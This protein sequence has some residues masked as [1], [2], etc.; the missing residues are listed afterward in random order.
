MRR[1]DDS[2]ISNIV[3]TVMEK[4]AMWW[5]IQTVVGMLNTQSDDGISNIDDALAFRM[6]AYDMMVSEC[7]T[8]VRM[9]K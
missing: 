2:E 7:V 4:L 6:T 8:G 9:W 3:P 5:S 1:F